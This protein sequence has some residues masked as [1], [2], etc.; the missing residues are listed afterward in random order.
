[1]SINDHLNVLAQIKPKTA[2]PMHYALIAEN[3]ADP[4]PFIDRC[5]KLGIK[6]KNLMVAIS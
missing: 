3:T 4:K 5:K 2:F 1:M 6:S